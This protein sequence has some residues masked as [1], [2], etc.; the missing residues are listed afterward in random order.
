[1]FVLFLLP[2]FPFFPTA[3]LRWHHL[4][5]LSAL[6]VLP[7]EQQQTRWRRPRR[8]STSES[9]ASAEAAHGTRARLRGQ[10]RR[11]Q[12]RLRGR[13]RRPAPAREEQDA[14]SQVRRRRRRR[15]LQRGRRDAAAERSL[16]AATPDNAIS[17]RGLSSGVVNILRG[18]RYLNIRSWVYKAFP[19]HRCNVAREQP[20]SKRASIAK[21]IHPHLRLLPSS[22]P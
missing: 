14:E 22:S 20:E 9:R 15:E 6:Q 17:S 13:R 21:V 2:F 4:S 5:G 10:Q 11:L 8:L 1:M 16:P 18:A 3:D 7:I 19:F 12:Q